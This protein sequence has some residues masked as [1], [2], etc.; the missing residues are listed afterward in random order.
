MDKI[1]DSRG[2]ARTVALFAL[3]AFVLVAIIAIRIIRIQAEKKF[4]DMD[5]TIVAS[6]ERE[7]QVNY[8]QDDSLYDT[9]AVFDI[10]TK[11]FIEPA[12]AKQTVKPYGNSKEHQGKYLLI[13]F[14]EDHSISSK[15]VAP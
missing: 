9:V 4:E 1:K 5:E 15:W 7:A 11:K 13:T 10:E 3:I 8:L 14:E 6:A 12:K 2:I